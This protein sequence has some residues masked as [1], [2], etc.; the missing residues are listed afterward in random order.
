MR[1]RV[2]SDCRA[3]GLLGDAY[4]P[5]K[6]LVNSRVNLFENVSA[7]TRTNNN[8][9]TLSD[10]TVMDGCVA[11]RELRENVCEKI[12]PLKMYWHVYSRM[13]LIRGKK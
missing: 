1:R 8:T 6:S 4:R 2:H 11:R 7:C 13:H 10:N 3:R 5:R 9:N 12:G